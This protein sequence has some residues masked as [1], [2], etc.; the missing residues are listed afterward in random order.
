[1]IDFQ[2][3]STCN[4]GSRYL[5][6]KYSYIIFYNICHYPGSSWVLGCL[7]GSANVHIDQHKGN[8]DRWTWIFFSGPTLTQHCQMLLHIVFS[9]VTDNG[10][11]LSHR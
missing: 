7:G 11:S 10:S 8:V 1:M 4:I 5:D 6:G 9:L 2:M 3:K